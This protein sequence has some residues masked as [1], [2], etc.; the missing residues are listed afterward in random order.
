MD[1]D[2]INMVEIYEGKKAGADSLTPYSSCPGYS[3][4]AGSDQEE[5]YQKIYTKPIAARFNAMAPG[6]N[7]T[8]IDITGMQELCGYDTVIRGSSP[9]CSTEL[10]TPDEWLQFEYSQDLLYHYNTGYGNELSGT[11]GFPWVNTTMNLLSAPSAD[12]DLYVSFTHR[13]LPPTVLVALGLFNN[14]QF[15]GADNINATMPTNQVNYGRAW[16]SSKIIPFLTNVAIERMNCSTSYG[17]ENQTDPTY[18]RVL[19]NQSPQTLPGCFDGPLESC[20][21]AGLQSFLSD[22]GQMLGGFS[23]KC[24]VDYSNST[25]TVTFYSSPNNGTTVGKKR[26]T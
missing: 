14:S 15:S 20:S 26:H 23:E 9:F 11:I 6:F 8:R 22:R 18:Y 7:F 3:S 4:S 19:V 1:D 12:Q 25:N 10:F 24:G 17:F 21:A 13:E 2:Q 16:V 5:E